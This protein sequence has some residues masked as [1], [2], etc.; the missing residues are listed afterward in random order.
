[1]T[2]RN[3]VTIHTQVT[4]LCTPQ[5]MYLYTPGDACAPTSARARRRVHTSAHG[6]TAHDRRNSHELLSS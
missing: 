3:H 1:M 5:S 2:A 4:T 6:S